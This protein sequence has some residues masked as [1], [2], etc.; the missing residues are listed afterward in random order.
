MRSSM[1]VSASFE[2]SIV[3]DRVDNVGVRNRS[4]QGG[5]WPINPNDGVLSSPP[6]AMETLRAP[7]ECRECLFLQILGP[8]HPITS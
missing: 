1:N 8:A 7:P 4:S 3:F 6:G 2:G 5:Q